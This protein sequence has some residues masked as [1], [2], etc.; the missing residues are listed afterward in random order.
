MAIQ[1]NYT[2][3]YTKFLH[4]EVKG[5]Y[6]LR[7]NVDHTNVQTIDCNCFVNVDANGKEKILCELLEKD[8]LVI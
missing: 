4:W 7:C 6:R 1:S 8:N 3:N 5:S 2:N